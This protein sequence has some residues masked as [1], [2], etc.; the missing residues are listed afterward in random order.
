[1]DG[2]TKVS[3][4]GRGKIWYEWIKILRK[5]RVF[6]GEDLIAPRTTYVTVD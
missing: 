4:A 3:H 1:L 6:E 2:K 5:S